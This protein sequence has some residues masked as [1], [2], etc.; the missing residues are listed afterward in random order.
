MVS[1][2]LA[3]WEARA[4]SSPSETKLRAV[5]SSIARSSLSR[6]MG[7][8]AA[9]KRPDSRMESTADLLEVALVDE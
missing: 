2:F 4:A 3:F 6:R 1:Y 5:T 8:L 7:A 9:P